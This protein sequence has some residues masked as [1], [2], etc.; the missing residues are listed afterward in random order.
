[1]VTLSSDEELINQIIRGD[2]EA[3]LALYDKYAARVYALAVQILGDTMLA[4]EIT[5]DSFMK[6]WSR[7]RQFNPR[8]GKLITWLLTIT[9][10]TALDRLR[11]EGRRP[12][13]SQVQDPE[14]ILKS[15]PNSETTTEENRWRSMYFAVQSLPEEH[16]AVIDLAYYKGLSQSEIAEVLDWPLGTVKTRIRDAMK[17]LR[18][19]WK[20]DMQS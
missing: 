15:I 2:Q 20:Q 11:F 16:R 4:E 18:E 17:T 8:R 12:I 5:Q 1:M 3:F 13:L 7:A 6:V 19:I 14:E 9:R 10:T